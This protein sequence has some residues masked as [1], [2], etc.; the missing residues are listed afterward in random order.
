MDKQFLLM[1]NSLDEDYILEQLSESILNYKARK[2]PMNKAKVS[3]PCHVL[4][5]KDA[6]KRE[7]LDTLAKEVAQINQFTST[8]L[9][10][11]N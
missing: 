3:E 6:I 7:G 4:I 1:V 11:K 9:K 2:S 10:N 5:T 8:F